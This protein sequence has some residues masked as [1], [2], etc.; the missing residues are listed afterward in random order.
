MYTINCGGKLL[1]FDQP[2][3]MGII[4][5]TPDS[6]YT[7]SRMQAADD[8]I[9]QA[10]KMLGNG[11]AIIDIGGQSTRP[12]AGMVGAEEE[13]ERVVPA[14]KAIL[15][16][17]PEAIISVDTFYAT[18]A[19][20]AVK[21]GAGM[22]NDVSGGMFD[23]KMLETVAR[24]GMPYICMH[25]KGTP[26]T[27]HKD[28]FYTDVVKEVFDYFIERIDVCKHAGIKDV[29]IDPGFG[30][31]KSIAYNLQLL[32]QLTVFKMLGKPLLLGISRKSTIYKTLGITADKALNGTTVLHTIGLLNGASILRVHDVKEAVECIKLVEAYQQP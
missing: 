8:V 29:I 11:A 3:V 18:V 16:C 28:P 7:G 30:F 2:I 4:N 31:A 9:K 5:V 10:E 19:E 20:A 12:G 21:A 14:I 17:F 1:A 15:S 13:C 32:Q 26:Q 27:M 24:S 6:F 25:T 23:E 22:V